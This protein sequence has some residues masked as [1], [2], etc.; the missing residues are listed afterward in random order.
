MS[1]RRVLAAFQDE[2]PACACSSARTH[3]LSLLWTDRICPSCSC[4]PRFPWLLWLPPWPVPHF[5]PRWPGHRC[6][7]E[8]V[9]AWCNLGSN[10]DTPKVSVVFGSLSPAW[11]MLPICHGA[12]LTHPSPEHQGC[13]C[14]QDLKPRK[15]Q[16][17]ENPPS[18]V[19]GQGA[20]PGGAGAVPGLMLGG[21]KGAQRGVRR[22]ASA[23]GRTG[24]V[25][26]LVLSG[27]LFEGA[28]PG[29]APHR[30]RGWCPAPTGEG[31]LLGCP[32]R[33]RE[34]PAPGTCPPFPSGCRGDA[35][36]SCLLQ[37]SIQEALN[38]SHFFP[39]G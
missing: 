28:A 9:L 30:S 34:P 23:Q 22:A 1:V 38:S 15:I 25:L 14:P 37:E 24:E 8:A 27:A 11:F 35:L 19:A 20:T 3:R 13:C 26:I 21:M 32:G 36:P 2:S 17:R 12:A 33:Q 18:R 4:T 39:V 5:S 6:A 7:L 31:T 10:T 29:T 16:A